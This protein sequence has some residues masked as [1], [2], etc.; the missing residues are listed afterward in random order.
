[1]CSTIS[2]SLKQRSDD[3]YDN[4]YANGFLSSNGLS[5][6]GGGD[7]SEETSYFIDGYN[8]TRDCSARGI[9]CIFESR[10]I[11]KA[12]NQSVGHALD[13]TDQLTLP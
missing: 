3:H 12:D 10:R 9:E 13:G 11:D 5:E 7:R 4:T 6:D 1:M 8:Q 2:C